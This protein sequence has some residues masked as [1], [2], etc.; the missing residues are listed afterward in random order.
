MAERYPPHAGVA[1][2]SREPFTPEEKARAAL[3]ADKLDAACKEEKTQ[4]EEKLQ[5][6]LDEN[7]RLRE[8]N[9]RWIRRIQELERR[10]QLIDYIGNGRLPFPK[11]YTVKEGQRVIHRAADDPRT[12]VP[13]MMVMF[14]TVRRLDPTLAYVEWDCDSKHSSPS[15]IP[16]DFI[17]PIEKAEEESRLEAQGR[18][19]AE[20]GKEFY[21]SLV[22]QPPLMKRK[23]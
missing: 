3:L 7:A 6:L 17:R 12:A 23:P 2:P 13:A 20:F 4:R 22:D 18:R 14:G 5:R 21:P 16:R 1:E 9:V 10:L 15:P 8:E 19:L 11:E